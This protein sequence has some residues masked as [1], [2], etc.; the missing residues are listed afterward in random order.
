MDEALDIDFNANR[1]PVGFLKPFMEAF[2]SEDIAGGEAPGGAP[3]YHGLVDF[4]GLKY[5]EE[6]YRA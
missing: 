4:K 6:G 1:V 5:R 3:P 2:T